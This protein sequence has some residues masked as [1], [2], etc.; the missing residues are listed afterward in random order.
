MTRLNSVLALAMAAS[1]SFGGIARAA[2]AVPDAT[3][4]M[5]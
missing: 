2:D 5:Q 1:M 3:T 4:D